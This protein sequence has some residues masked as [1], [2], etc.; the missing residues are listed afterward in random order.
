MN[1]EQIPTGCHECEHK[2]IANRNICIKYICALHDLAIGYA[3]KEKRFNTFCEN[4][5]T[6]EMQLKLSEL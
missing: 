1:K 4:K 5:K 3:V 2:R 6:F